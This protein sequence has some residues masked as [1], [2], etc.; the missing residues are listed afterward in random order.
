M[1]AY[2]F[3]KQEQSPAALVARDI[4]VPHPGANQLLV[5]VHARSLNYRDTLIR[6]GRYAIPSR[7]GVI[8]LSDCFRARPL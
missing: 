7:E 4:D 2:L 3:E 1:K 8:P 5:R 6:E